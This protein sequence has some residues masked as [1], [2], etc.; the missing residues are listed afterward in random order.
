MIELEKFQGHI[1]LYCKGHYKVKKTDFFEGLKMIWAIRCGYD[2]ETFRK[3]ILIYIANE[4]YEIISTCLPHKLPYLM[5]IIHRE[6]GAESWTKPQGLTP[7]EAI[8]WEYRSII[9]GMKV[10]ELKEGRKRYSWLVKLPKP[11]NKLFNRILNGKGEYEDY[12]KV[13]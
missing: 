6:V 9:S 4:M 7:I 11:Q 3:D 8:I 12:K 10:K 13:I 2:Y 1:V 5:E